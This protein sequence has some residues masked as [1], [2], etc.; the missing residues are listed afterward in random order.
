MSGPCRAPSR[1][2][3][4]AGAAAAV[5]LVPVLLAGCSGSKD[6]QVSVK[7]ALGARPQVTFPKKTSPEKDLAVKT[8]AGGKG[9]AARK[10]DLVVADYVGY[11]W[12]KSGSKMLASTYLAGKPQAFS[13]GTL[14]PGLDKA[15]DGAK[16]GA[17]IVARIPPKEAYGDEGDSSHQVE[18]GD[19]LVYVLDVRA[20]YAKTA[21]ARGARSAPTAPGLPQVGSPD[22]GTAP[23]VTIP[24]A[25][26]PKTLRTSVLIK[27]TGA[28]VRTD[29]LVALQ[30]TGVFWRNGRTFDSSWRTGRPAAV[31]IGDGQVIQGWVKGLVGQAVGSRVLLVVPPSMGYGAKGLAQAGI[32]GTDTLVFVV[33]ILGAH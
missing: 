9:P 26:P 33:D 18:A 15:L 30:Y 12:N 22:A 20:V 29:Q 16:A 11:R 2:R 5:L 14:V 32:K 17:R 8:L 28:A 3:G 27:G 6:V 7:G 21:A 1:R 19:S 13:T 4:R 31:T 23:P 24:K 10:G 25:A